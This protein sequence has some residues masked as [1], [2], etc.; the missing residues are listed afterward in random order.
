MESN[1]YF[2]FSPLQQLTKAVPQILMIS[3]EGD[4]PT[5][6]LK[7]QRTIVYVHPSHLYLTGKLWPCANSVITRL[8]HYCK[9]LWCFSRTE[10]VMQQFMHM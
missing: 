6:S 4:Q 9:L 2:T 5:I 7:A 10:T 1:E 8:G 3:K